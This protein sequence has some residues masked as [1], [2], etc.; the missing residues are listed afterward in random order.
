MSSVRDRRGGM[1]RACG[2]RVVLVL[3]LA[4]GVG[5]HADATLRDPTRPPMIRPTARTHTVHAPAWN[6]TSTLISRKRRIAVINRRTVE[7][8]QRVGGA[9]VVWIGPGRARLRRGGRQF[10][11]RLLP[12]AVKRPA[13][14]DAARAGTQATAEAR[15]Q[16]GVP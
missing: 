15:R 3:L 16:G 11:I 12:A 10:T 7:A 13:R 14:R 9:L 5:V 8:G 2:R 4:A 1:R 6:L